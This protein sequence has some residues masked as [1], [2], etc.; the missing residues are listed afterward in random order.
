[1]KS[2]PMLR[3][4][5]VTWLSSPDTFSKGICRLK[6]PEVL[7]LLFDGIL[8]GDSSIYHFEVYINR[9]KIRM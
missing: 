8:V 4:E 5:R 6:R 3:I 2:V 9:R 1:M 7:L